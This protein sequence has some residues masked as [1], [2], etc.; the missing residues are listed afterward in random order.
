MVVLLVSSCENVF[1]L[2]L[3]TDD[4]CVPILNVELSLNGMFEFGGQLMA[5]V[6][7]HRTWVF[8]GFSEMVK[9]YLRGVSS[10]LLPFSLED[11]PGYD[12]QNALAKVRTVR[13]IPVFA[14][15]F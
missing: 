4:H 1:E 11:V 12:S 13:I 3:G 14:L 7:R 6:A 15:F 8:S 5:H 2:L 9:C 10:D